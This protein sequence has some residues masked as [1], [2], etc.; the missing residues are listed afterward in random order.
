M[1]VALLQHRIAVNIR[2][3]QFS[4]VARIRWR[5][6]VTDILP[7]LLEWAEY[8][9]PWCYVAAARLHRIETE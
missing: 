1:D 3:R 2:I 4:C 9:W 7:E 5:Q 6:V 8:F